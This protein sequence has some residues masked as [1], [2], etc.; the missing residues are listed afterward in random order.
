VS[1][2]L[3]PPEIDSEGKLLYYLRLACI[4]T[5]LVLIVIAV[6]ASIF[7]PWLIDPEFKIDAVVYTGLLGVLLSLFGLEVVTRAVK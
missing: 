7:G 4:I 6:L 5:I 2:K 1:N 3:H